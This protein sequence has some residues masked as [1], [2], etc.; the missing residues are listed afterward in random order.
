M[1]Q[2]ENKL[3]FLGKK[4]I[5]NDWTDED[6]LEA[7]NNIIQLEIYLRGLKHKYKDSF[8]NVA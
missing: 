6:L 7:V 1:T 4:Y 8:S 2:T 5:S 3:V